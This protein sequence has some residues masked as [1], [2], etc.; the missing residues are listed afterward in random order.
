Y[1]RDSRNFVPVARSL[2]TTHPLPVQKLNNTARISKSQS[3][4]VGV[5]GKFM[6]LFH[7]AF[8]MFEQSQ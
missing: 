7:A 1:T 4:A 8:H 6:E 3:L 2:S 5:H